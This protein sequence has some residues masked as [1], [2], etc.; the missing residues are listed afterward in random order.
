MKIKDV[1]DKVR[2]QDDGYCYLS[3]WSKG[4]REFVAY[5]CGPG[6]VSAYFGDLSVL[7]M[8]PD[9]AHGP[10]AGQVSLMIVFVVE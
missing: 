9:I 2:D 1:V 5:L 4:K 7:S 6:M 3:V 8:Y 10:S